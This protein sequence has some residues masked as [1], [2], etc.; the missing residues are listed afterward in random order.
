[1]LS[2]SQQKLTKL[3][4]IHLNKHK[5]L[6]N[7]KKQVI[8]KKMILLVSMLAGVM[9]FSGCVDDKESASVTAVREAKAAQLNAL[10]AYSNAQAAAQQA[11]ADTENALREAKVAYETAKA[12]EKQAQT[13]IAKAQA[14]QAMAAAQNEIQRMANELEIMAIEHQIAMLDLQ[15][16][17]E[18]ALKNA[19]DQSQQL[20]GGLYMAYQTAATNLLDAQQE[21]ARKKIELAKLQAGL[22]NSDETS[23]MLINDQKRIIANNEQQIA[24]WTAMIEVFEAQKAPEEAKAELV[25]E[26]AALSQLAQDQKKALTAANKAGQEMGEAWSDVRDQKYSDLAQDVYS[27]GFAYLVDEDG[28]NTGVSFNDYILLNSYEAT[29]LGK[30][31]EATVDTYWFSI[32]DDKGNTTYTA[33]MNRMI[34]KTVTKTETT[35]PGVESTN[36]Y[37]AYPTY[38]YQL[39]AEGVK[40]YVAAIKANVTKNE[41]KALEAANKAL[42]AQQKVV[43]DLEKAE[44]KDEV[45]IEE[46]KSMLPGLQTDVNTAQAALDK[47][48]AQVAAIQTTFDTM[49]AEAANWEATIKAYNAASEAYCDAQFAVDKA[50]DAYTLQNKKVLALQA[51]VDGQI[52]IDGNE[53]TIDGAIAYAERKI[54]MANRIIMFAKQ[55]IVDLESANSGGVTDLAIEKLEAEI[56]IL[57]AELPA[58]EKIVA[59]TKA[60]L[61]AATAAQAE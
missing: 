1:M 2:F 24:E 58:L 5:L 32:T 34:Q 11:I 7:L 37:K 49:A 18:T 30:P 56:E 55:E 22:V 59:D 19:D 28:N 42:A 48:N 27:N 38:Y 51:V 23:Q 20:L 3:N 16:Q 46:A 61:D 36:T 40:A 33:V 12:A 4:Q 31:V 35:A 6:S 29:S 39:N 8:M 26:K 44:I 60:A 10:A 52:M 41:G 57:E 9:T 50:Y 21:I 43:A 25:T 14:Q 54:E 45:A 47:A 53:Y 15:T 17:Y 13:E